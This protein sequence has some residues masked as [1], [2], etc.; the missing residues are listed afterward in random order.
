VITENGRNV[1]T[2]VTT[3]DFQLAWHSEM[4]PDLWFLVRCVKSSSSTEQVDYTCVVVDSNLNPLPGVPRLNNAMTGDGVLPAATYLNDRLRGT[5]STA[6]ATAPEY[7]TGPVSRQTTPAAT[8]TTS[9]ALDGSAGSTM[10]SSAG[11]GVAFRDSGGRDGYNTQETEQE[12]EHPAATGSP[13]SE[14]SNAQLMALT[15]SGLHK[16]AGE[17]TDPWLRKVMQ[18]IAGS[19]IEALGS[20]GVDSRS[21]WEAA[22]LQVLV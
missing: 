17:V 4:C 6:S 14:G 16:D 19:I 20:G 13:K 22:V 10:G 9:A 5:V 11:V 7:V 8:A 21:V 18:G 3:V 12:R 15:W 1:S 2:L